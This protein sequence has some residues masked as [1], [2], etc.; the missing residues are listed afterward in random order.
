MY[1]SHYR[2]P[3]QTRWLA[4][5]KLSV[6]I[7]TF[8]NATTLP[9]CLDSVRWADEIIVLDSFSTDA[10]LEIAA[11][12]PNCRTFQHEFLGYGAQK[13]L[14]LEKTS[15]PWVLLLDADEALT[16]ESQAE[17]QT[18]L[19]NRPGAVGYTLPRLEQMFWRMCDRRTRLNHFLRLFRREAGRM[20]DMPVHAAPEVDG[21]IGRLRHPFYHFGEIDIHTKVEKINSYSS[22]LVRDKVARGRRRVGLTM[23]L[24]P[25][26]Y[27][28]K[29]YLLKRNFFNGWA[30][31]ITSVTAAYY[32][33]LKY[34]KVHEYYQDRSGLPVDIPRRDHGPS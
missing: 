5:E 28:F 16:R 18:L 14:A 1:Y 34:A 21:P 32:V 24:Y 9:F 15:H 22:G 27:F 30:G 11:S 33:F 3:L 20:G 7:T 10:T 17:I 23:I 6:F 19:E 12:Y 31:F 26:L 29:T 2:V 13:Q 25:P 8:N 4:M